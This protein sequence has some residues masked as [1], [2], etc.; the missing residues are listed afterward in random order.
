MTEFF[1]IIADIITE[2]PFAIGAAVLFPVI[3]AVCY[4]GATY[5]RG[6]KFTVLGEDEILVLAVGHYANGT[7]EFYCSDGNAYYAPI[8][9]N[10]Q[11][12]DIIHKDDL[13]KFKQIRTQKNKEVENTELS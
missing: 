6:L 9:S 7:A 3:L 1:D 5:E 12:G 2:E 10:I 8:G 13:I 11:E 4:I